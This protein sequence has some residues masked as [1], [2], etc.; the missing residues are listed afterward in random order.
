MKFNLYYL[1]KYFGV[2]FSFYLFILG[3]G[4]LFLFF[5]DNKKEG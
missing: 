5:Y 3:F 2:W 4:F 1:D